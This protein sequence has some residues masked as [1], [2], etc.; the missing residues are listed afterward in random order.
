MRVRSVCLLFTLTLA[1]HAAFAAS[2]PKVPILFIPAPTK[3]AGNL[4]P[5]IEQVMRQTKASLESLGYRGEILL[6]PGETTR[7]LRRISEKQLQQ[8]DVENLSKPDIAARVCQ[9]MAY[10]LGV[11]MSVT[12][13]D[14]TSVTVRLTLVNPDTEQWDDLDPIAAQQVEIIPNPKKPKRKEIK[15]AHQGAGEQIAQTLLER[16]QKLPAASAQQRQA[17]AS[18]HIATAKEHLAHKRWNETLGE[19]YQAMALAP[20]L[21]EPYALAGEVAAA[22]ED[23]DSARVQY[24]RALKRSPDDPALWAKLANAYLMQSRYD[25]V[26]QMVEKRAPETVEAS[27]VAAKTYLARREVVRRAGLDRDARNDLKKAQEFYGR[28]VAL[29]PEQLD[30]ATTHIDLLAQSFDYDKMADALQRAIKVAPERADFHERL[31]DVLAKQKKYDEAF[32]EMA[33]AWSLTKP[34][35]IALTDETYRKSA[36]I[37]DARIE[38]LFA[39]FNK[40]AAELDQSKLTREQGFNQM[41]DL[42]QLSQAV[43]KALDMVKPPAA[44]EEAHLHRQTAA[45]LVSQALGAAKTFIDTGAGDYQSRVSMLLKT[46]L[47]ELRNAGAKARS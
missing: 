17:L 33:K 4:T 40:I 38:R 42:R 22:Q 26:I 21:P 39:D 13:A 31:S 3:E 28:A 45:S 25:V 24:E 30:L 1:I 37:T 23:W 27:V 8:S 34:Q 9:V 19:S 2:L 10:R 7:F 20:D 15:T 12:Q 47:E 16:L 44:F 14:A 32:D 6:S 36:Q 5:H 41:Q 11:L 43:V 29:A 18:A 46:A 35:P